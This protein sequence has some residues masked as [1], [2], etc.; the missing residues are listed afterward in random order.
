MSSVK[1]KK[2][3]PWEPHILKLGKFELSVQMSPPKP[4]QSQCVPLTSSLD[5]GF[6]CCWCSGRLSGACCCI[7]TGTMDIHQVRVE[8]VRGSFP[9]ICEQIEQRKKDYV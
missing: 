1:E 6:G 3:S 7:L 8:V 2:K 9:N 5:P 4:Q